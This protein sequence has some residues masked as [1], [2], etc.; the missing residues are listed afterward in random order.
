MKT[1]NSKNLNALLLLFIIIGC[2]LGCKKDTAPSASTQTAS[3]VLM[4]T[5]TLNGTVNANGFSSTVEFEYGTATSYGNIV[6]A[7]QSPVTGNKTTNVSADINTEAN[8]T[9]HFRLKTSNAVGLTYGNDISFTTSGQVPTVTTLSSRSLSS[10][11]FYLNG[12]VNANG[13]STTVEFEYGTTTSYGNKI[14]ANQS[15]LTG[16]TN[17][18]VIVNITGL[19]IGTIYHYRV[20]A[21]NS[22][23]TSYG[24]DMTFIYLY[25]GATY[26]GGLVFYL[27]GGLH[28]LVCT[29]NDQSSGIQWYNSSYVITDATGTSIGTGQANTTKIVS[30]QGSGSYAAKLCDDLVLNGYTDWFLPSHEEL[31]FMYN[32]LK[33]H[34]TYGFGVAVYWSSQEQTLNNAWLLNF[35]WGGSYTYNKNNFYSVR[36]VRAF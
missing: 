15:P 2:M 19:T 25:S 7:S 21:V 3:N 9:Y 14:T 31:Q 26:Q 30:V 36:A 24:N 22:F 17:T 29:P 16:N 23:G 13:F 11:S 35:D 5:A 6:T 33:P 20:K 12:T 1:K 27:D 32:N 8:K 28:G 34:S 10:N 4:N 18:D